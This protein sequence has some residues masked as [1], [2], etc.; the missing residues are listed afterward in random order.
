MSEDAGAIS[1]QIHSGGSGYVDS[2]KAEL[3]DVKHRV[4]LT[5]AVRLRRAAIV[6]SWLSV[7]FGFTQGVTAV[8]FALKLSSDTLFGFG[9]NAILDSTSSIVVLWRFHSKDLYSESRERKAC[10]IIAILFVVS[11]TSLLTMSIVTLVK[12]TKEKQLVTLSILS[13]V[14]GCS[15]LVLGII[16]FGIG[17]KLESKSL[18]TD[19]V[20]TF[21]GAVIS[22]SAF[23]AI[24]LYEHNSSLWYIDNVFGVGCSLFLYLFAIRLF[25][26]FCS[27]GSSVQS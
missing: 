13:L 26:Q 12:E 18:M 16:K 20:I 7:L 11:S 14:N 25:C 21:V 1:L 10:F 24:D 27:S 9:L 22:F 19:S 23:L 6:V 8:A 2:E 17:Y 15:N 3:L 5:V 4:Q